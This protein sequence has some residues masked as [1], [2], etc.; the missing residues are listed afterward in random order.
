MKITN[1][2]AGYTPWIED[3]EVGQTGYIMLQYIKVI[4]ALTGEITYY[5]RKNA[6]CFVYPSGEFSYAIV[7]KSETE[8]ELDLVKTL[9]DPLFAPVLPGKNDT[10]KHYGPFTFSTTPELFDAKHP[11]VNYNMLVKRHHAA[12][13]EENM[14]ALDTVRKELC[15]YMPVFLE[16]ASRAADINDKYEILLQWREQD[17]I[18]SECLESLI[19][20]HLREYATSGDIKF[21]MGFAYSLLKAREHKLWKHLIDSYTKEQILQFAEYEINQK[22]DSLKSIQHDIDELQAGIETEPD[23]LN[24]DLLDWYVDV[25][26]P[27]YKAIHEIRKDLKKASKSNLQEAET[28]VAIELYDSLVS[29][30]RA[31]EDLDE[32]EISFLV[33]ESTRKEDYDILKDLRDAGKLSSQVQSK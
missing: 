30:F 17:E 7:R 2:V 1:R 11:I 29:K 13:E 21:T 28:V 8:W 15:E 14:E 27:A 20:P 6:V 5:I 10:K 19:L 31:N 3:L 33:T 18:I 25:L 32:E 16:T 26:L 24:Q 12:I 22:R 4:R 23:E 9:L